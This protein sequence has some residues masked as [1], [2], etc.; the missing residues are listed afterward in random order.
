MCAGVAD[1]I[2]SEFTPLDTVRLCRD[3]GR[4]LKQFSFSECAGGV[5]E[6]VGT[7]RKRLQA[8]LYEAA[9]PERV[10]LDAAVESVDL[11]AEKASAGAP[12]VVLQ[13]QA[14]PVQCRL[15]VGAD[16]VRS[17]VAQS[18]GVGHI[19]S[20]RQ[21]GYRGNLRPDPVL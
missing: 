8:L 12:A 19:N 4:V 11:N 3:S 14:T 6:L 16:G 18:L 5:P 2:R 9:D 7:S 10:V 13:S 20:A 1:A 21:A 15:L 17:K